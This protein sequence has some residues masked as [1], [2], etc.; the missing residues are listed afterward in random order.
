VDHNRESANLGSRGSC[1]RRLGLAILVTMAAVLTRSAPTCRG[2][3]SLVTRPGGLAVGAGRRL[4]G[5][6]AGAGMR[7]QASKGWFVY[8]CP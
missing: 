1:S 2:P 5:L 6:L 3:V 8:K 7:T 4:P